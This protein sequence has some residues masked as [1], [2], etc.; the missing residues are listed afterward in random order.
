MRELIYIRKINF[1]LIVGREKEDKKL[2]L[3]YC[4]FLN[5][6]GDLDGCICVM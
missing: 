4:V 1:D 3:Y 2:N 6:L 5:L